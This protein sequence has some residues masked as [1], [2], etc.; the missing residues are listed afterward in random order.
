MTRPLTFGITGARGFI[1]SELTRH[2]RSSG[3]DVIPLS[4]TRPD[5][6]D[7]FVPFELGETPS[8]ESLRGLD[9]LVHGAYDFKCRDAAEHRRKNIEGS[10]ALMKQAKAA[11]VSRIAF[12]SSLSAFPGCRSA[13][14]RG[15]MEVEEAAIGLGA[16]A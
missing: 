16:L 8:I 1:G 15:K 5:G 13:Y 12:L 4:R 9:V 7:R 11:G 6:E 10:I 3:H 2:L 14:G